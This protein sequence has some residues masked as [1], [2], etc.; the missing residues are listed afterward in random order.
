MRSG[1][2][3]VLLCVLGVGFAV[4]SA[5]AQEPDGQGT[6]L[7][8]TVVAREC[9]DYKDIMAN[10]ARNDIQESLRDLGK[11]TVYKAGQ[12]I[13]PGI[14]ESNDPGCIPLPGW[15][16]TLG[17]GY[18]SRAVSGPWGSL[19]IVTSPYDTEIV[20]QD[21]VP[22]LDFAGRPTDDFIEGATTIELT[23]AQAKRAATA[24]S[25]WVQGGT[26]SDPI[27]YEQ[28]PDQF[29]FGAL[30]CAIDNL[31]GDNVEW[32]AY[33][34]GTEHVFC[35]AYYVRPPPT[36]GTIVI[37]K[38]VQGTEGATHSFTFD[39]NL[40]FNDGNIFSLRVVDGEAASKTFYRAATGPDDP[41]WVVREQVPAG[42]ALA[43]L[44]C[45]SAGGSVVAV[46]LA[47]ARADIRL[48]PGDVVTCTYVNE[49]R[50][51]AGQ[52]FIRK[53]TRGG[54][55]TFDFSVTPAGGGTS[56]EAQAE[57]LEERVAVDAQP[58][59]LTLSPG[60]YRIEES[61]PESRAGRW[62]QDAVICDGQSLASSESTEVTITDGAGATCTF[63]NTFIPSGS[64]AID[65][66][67]LEGVTTTGFV[68]SPVDDPDT[69]YQKS[70]T[71]A[72]PGVPV[73]ATGSNTS[74]LPLGRYVIQ[75]LEPGSD[76]TGDWSLVQVICN[77]RIVPAVEGR[78]V[79]TITRDHPRQRCRF[80]NTFRA[81]PPPTPDPPG[82]D[83]IP[84]GPEAE[85][86]VTKRAGRSIV[87]VG[88]VVT[89]RVIVANRGD[90][91]AEEV[92][93]GDLPAAG[94]RVVSAG[95]GRQ[96]CHV[97][98]ILYCRI[99]ALRPGRS[100]SIKLRLRL[101]QTG[102]FKNGAAVISSSPEANHRNNRAASTVRVRKVPPFCLPLATPAS[103]PR[104][105]AAC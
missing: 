102:L 85:L 35:F 7:F 64:I 91:T 87:T 34:Q 77:E 27:L 66:V 30:R 13:D 93:A 101:L 4:P 19:S 86:I 45:Q 82:P 29:G 24:S 96:R 37:R 38:E 10:R 2:S 16:F 80:T 68:I 73:R 9:P 5:L 104:A 33:P 84:G 81:T 88:E 63:E 25:L 11:N 98:R 55:G 6:D 60:S 69:Q 70:A 46:D 18:R 56:V 14:E 58:S 74:R 90:A 94:A 52:L 20:T 103:H 97:G 36:S 3:A 48:A 12:P 28:Y 39:G 76:A 92:I 49:V 89:F 95:T 22:L 31:N 61:L 40:S 47:G 78:V 23:K 67:S 99:T 62:R 79:V 54:L 65:K 72:E 50:P 83:P 71:T 15:R 32:I 100:V 51:P 57:T 105:R 42:W 26:P 75:E 43:E 17:T 21:R 59:P 1:L 44:S 8:V 53:L 41:P